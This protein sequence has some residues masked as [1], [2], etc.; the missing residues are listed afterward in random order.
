MLNSWKR[1]F[2]IRRM[3]LRGCTELSS[4]HVYTW[5]E[6]VEIS[7]DNTW[8]QI[9]A[10]KTVTF[11]QLYNSNCSNIVLLFTTSVQNVGMLL[12]CCIDVPQ[13]SVHWRRSCYV[14]SVSSAVRLRLYLRCTRLLHISPHQHDGRAAYNCY[15]SVKSP[16]YL[17]TLITRDATRIKRSSVSVAMCIMI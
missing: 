11:V 13:L 16:W 6:F 8:M 2:K 4:S 9:Y 12:Y 3:Q 7:L 14:W 15:L 5:L 17:L 10:K 1:P